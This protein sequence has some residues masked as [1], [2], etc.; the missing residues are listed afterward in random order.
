MGA[1]KSVMAEDMQRVTDIFSEYHSK[2]TAYADVQP[3]ANFEWLTLD[4]NLIIS[5]NLLFK[6]A[7]LLKPLL[8]L[9]LKYWS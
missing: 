6:D 8:T 2:R 5:Q 1:S 7:D 9:R 4:G 3:S